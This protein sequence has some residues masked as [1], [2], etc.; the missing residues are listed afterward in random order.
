[1][2]TYYKGVLNNLYFHQEAIQNNFDV[3]SNLGTQAE[4]ITF[5][6]PLII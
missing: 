6:H 4:L 1:M 5:Q 3:W 2:P